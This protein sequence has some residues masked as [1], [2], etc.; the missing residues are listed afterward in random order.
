MKTILL[1]FDDDIHA[2]MDKFKKKIG[3]KSWE[4]LFTV[5]FGLSK[6]SPHDLIERSV[7]KG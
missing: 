2:K 7:Q 1:H 4:H 5:L 3:C 6:L